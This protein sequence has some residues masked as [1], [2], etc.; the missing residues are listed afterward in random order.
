M[1]R[2]N[3]SLEQQADTIARS[4][5]SEPSAQMLS[6]Q[7][8]S[9][10]SQVQRQTESDDMTIDE[11]I[12]DEIED[13]ADDEVQDGDSSVS[14]TADSEEVTSLENTMLAE[15]DEIPSPEMIAEPLESGSGATPAKD[16]KKTGKPKTPPAKK[17]IPRKITQIDID[18][19]AQTLTLI[20]NDGARDP[21]RKISSGKG[22]HNT[23]DDPC[24]T[25]KEKNCTPEVNVPVGRLGNADTK[26]KKGDEMAW[27][28][29]FVDTRGIGIHNSQPVPGEP[30]SHGC[31]RVGKGAEAEEFAKKIN[32][33]VIPGKTMVH[34]FGKAPTKPWFKAVP[35]KKSKKK[36]K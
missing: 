34:T 29:G 4:V 23:K 10:A 18:L 36:K 3:D 21:A 16:S 12:E 11:E 31:V 2:E 26:N 35:A 17:A 20:W 14:A 7:T 1:G 32:K 5:M 19:A 33:N 6:L 22:I 28:V 13:Q 9:S 8:A 15:A 25:Q 27:Y 30:A 24:K